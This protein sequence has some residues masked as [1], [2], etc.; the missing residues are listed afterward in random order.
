MFEV[1]VFAETLAAG[2]ELLEAGQAVVVAVETRREEDVIRLTAQSV[3]SLDNAVRD[4]AAGLRIFVRS[5]DVLDSIKGILGHQPRGK[6]KVRLL[7][8][9]ERAHEVE[10]SLP[11]GWAITPATR[12]AI[13]AVP[14]VAEVLET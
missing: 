3:Q 12:A 14:G 4:A 9:L 2:R 13:K 6:G 8:E 5:P 10:V 11:G 1:T 7:L